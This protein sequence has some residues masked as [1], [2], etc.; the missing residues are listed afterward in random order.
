MTA[1]ESPTLHFAACR[2]S[3]LDLEMRPGS[4]SVNSRLVVS[5]GWLSRRFTQLLSPSTEGNIF[6]FMNIALRGTMS[7]AGP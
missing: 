3:S 7:G 5:D 2:S 4:V 6:D 1:D